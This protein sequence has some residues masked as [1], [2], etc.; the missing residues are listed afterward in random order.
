MFFV[1]CKDFNCIN[2]KRCFLHTGI[3]RYME[4]WKKKLCNNM[5][6]LTDQHLP[7]DLSG[8]NNM[9]NWNNLSERWVIA[10]EIL[11]PVPIN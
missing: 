9:V 7:M 3:Y 1:Y 10:D 11:Y 2:C 8:N 4:H 6:Y 5:C